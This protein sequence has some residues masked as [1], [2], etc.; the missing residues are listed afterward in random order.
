MAGHHEAEPATPQREP[1]VTPPG[2]PNGDD[3]LVPQLTPAQLREPLLA[4]GIRVEEFNPSCDFVYGPENSQHL[5]PVA[6]TARYIPPVGWTK[7]GLRAS[8]PDGDESW[9]QNWQVA[10]HAPAKNCRQVIVSAIK[11]GF[12]VSN[13]SLA[14]ST[15]SDLS[16]TSDRHIY[17]G[18]PADARSVCHLTGV[19]CASPGL[20]VVPFR[21][22]RLARPSGS[23]ATD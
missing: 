17:P 8:S 3:H 13:G 6:P 9:V 23:C 22:Q 11:C 16:S 5:P 20:G 15:K 10:Y 7:L 2:S 14:S 4:V 19:Y 12:T 1:A 18:V 21:C